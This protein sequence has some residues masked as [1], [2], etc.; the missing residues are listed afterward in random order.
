M[1][2][3]DEVRRA[4]A[5][6]HDPHVPVSLE[7]MGMLREI[8]VRTDGTVRIGV[9][10]PCSGC[11]GAGMIRDNIQEAVGALPGVEEVVVEEG[12]HLFWSRDQ[13]DSDVRALM[14]K[15]GVQI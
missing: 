14:H 13:V 4:L 12:W 2:S 1:V 15:N 10:I 9:C 7:R 8:D 11:P 6:V 3:E 5:D